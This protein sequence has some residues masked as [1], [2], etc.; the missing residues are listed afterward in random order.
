VLLACACLSAAHAQEAMYT[1]AATMPSPGTGIVRQQF[2]FFRYG[3]NPLDPSVEQTD[4]V[5]SESSFA[6]GLDRGLALFV[7]VP[8]AFERESTPG[9]DDGDV[10]VEDINAMLKWRFYKHD[11]GGIDTV[12]A[13]LMGGAEVASGDSDEFS[14]GSVNPHIG[15]VL[16]I[17]KGRHGFNQDLLFTWNTGGTR[18][19]NLGGD[20]PSDAVHFNSAY[21]YRIWPDQFTSE[22]NGGWYVTAELNNLYETNGDFEVR[23]SPG[24]MYEGR[25]V[26]WEFMAQFP[27]YHDLGERAELDFAVGAGVRVSF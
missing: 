14:S 19:H 21:V 7:D 17:V 20:G 10:G 15:A 22:S 9:N 5:E 13:A 11:S 2:H 1:A 3:A 4:L 25:R 12:R 6:W 26:S 27:L 8:V 23:W 18:E 16:T 24:L